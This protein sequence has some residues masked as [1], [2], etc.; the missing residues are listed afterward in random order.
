ML[1]IRGTIACIN[2]NIVVMLDKIG[3]TWI[4]TNG[5]GDSLTDDNII[6]DITLATRDMKVD[7]LGQEIAIP[8]IVKGVSHPSDVR[9]AIHFDPNLEY[10]GSFS[11]TNT[12]LDIASERTNT[13]STIL[14]RQALSDTLGFAKFLVFADSAKNPV[15][16]FDSVEQI[17]KILSCGTLQ[18]RPAIS[19]IIVPPGCGIPEI[20]RYLHHRQIPKF[21]LFPNPTSS[22]MS[23]RTTE[24]IGDATIR[25]INSIGNIISEDHTN[26]KANSDHTFNTSALAGGVYVVQISNGSFDTH[27]RFIVQ[28]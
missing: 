16:Q 10:L 17:G 11:Q 12:A 26:L 8:I 20:S 22:E 27:L 25:I 4:T 24:D 15:V 19:T 14:T 21:S 6:S 18:T 13:R 3:D 2:D 28:R 23:I 5:M 7:T 1:L 9:L